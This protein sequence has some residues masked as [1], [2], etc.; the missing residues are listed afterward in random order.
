MIRRPPRSTLF[1]Y[2]TLFRSRDER[3][4]NCDA[5]AAVA[6]NCRKKIAHRVAGN[7]ERQ[8]ARDHSIDAHDFAARVGQWP[9]GISRREKYFRL[10]PVLRAQPAK[11]ANAVNYARRKRADKAH[12]IA[13]GNGQFAGRT[14]EESATEAAGRFTASMR[15]SARTRQGSPHWTEA[16]KSRPSPN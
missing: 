3:R 4:M 9:A 15:S 13:D 14:C 7:G 16:S 6:R 5:E 2:T 8:A 10:H 1:P 12:R 11:R